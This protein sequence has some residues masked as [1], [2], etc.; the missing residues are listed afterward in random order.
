VPLL[1]EEDEETKEGTSSSSG[2]GIV[3]EAKEGAI[4]EVAIL[5]KSSDDSKEGIP[6]AE[7][8]WSLLDEAKE[9]GPL[10]ACILSLKSGPK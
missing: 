2:C 8:G 4:P 3:A 6:D 5:S 10:D 9:G 1:D 7:E